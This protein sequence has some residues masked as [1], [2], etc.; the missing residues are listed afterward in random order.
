MGNREGW[1]PLAKAAQALVSN[2][3]GYERI[4]GPGR[5]FTIT[6]H[7]SNADKMLKPNLSYAAIIPG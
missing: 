6:K 2:S 4:V 7:R 5:A 1:G 3:L